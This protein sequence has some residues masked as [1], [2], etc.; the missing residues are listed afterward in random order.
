MRLAAAIAMATTSVAVAGPS[1]KAKP[2]ARAKAAEATVAIGEPRVAGSLTTAEVAAP[3]AK[4]THALRACHHPRAGATRILLGGEV[5]AAFTITAAGTVEHAAASGVDPDVASCV[6]D[7][8]GAVA[9][10]VAA[11]S[12]TVVVAVRYRVRL[13]RTMARVVDMARLRVSTEGPDVD[14]AEV[15]TARDRDR[16]L[17]AVGD[18]R[19]GFGSGRSDGLDS[20]GTVVVR[21]FDPAPPLDVAIGV[22]AAHQSALELCFA[23]DAPATT[24]TIEADA[25]GAVTRTTL[26]PTTDA[27]TTTCATAVIGALHFPATDEP[28]R[29]AIGYARTGDPRITAQQTFQL[30]R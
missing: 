7:V 25:T 6:T 12:T 11:A 14:L 10:P 3:L 27:A 22:V 2:K 5:A 4:A 23:S 1:A 29:F 20:L 13:D 18:P 28:T 24:F 26:D 9:F 17:R 30:R 21:D 19:P 15:M 16:E 8:L